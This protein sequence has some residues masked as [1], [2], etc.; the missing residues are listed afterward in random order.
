MRSW[1]HPNCGIFFCSSQ[2]QML[3]LATSRLRVRKS[4][5]A[6]F[7]QAFWT[8]S[9]ETQANR[10]NA[11]CATQQIRIT[12]W[13]AGKNQQLLS[14]GLCFLQAL[15]LPAILK[16]HFLLQFIKPFFHYYLFFPLF[17]L[18]KWDSRLLKQERQTYGQASKHGL[19][20]SFVSVENQH[21]TLITPTPKQLYH[22]YVY[23]VF[24]TLIKK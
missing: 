24:V 4:G 6:P 13:S 15:H 22:S 23:T 1:V 11:T 8:P 12:V 2:L 10:Q 14:T 21:Y 3:T 16:R 5:L 17:F 18:L 9:V 19:V 20:I 7:S